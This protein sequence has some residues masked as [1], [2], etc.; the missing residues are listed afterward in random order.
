MRL[1]RFPV[2]FFAAGIGGGGGLKRVFDF[3]GY[4]LFATIRE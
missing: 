4:F 2:M 3:G 1:A